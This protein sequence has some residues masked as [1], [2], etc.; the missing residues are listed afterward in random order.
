MKKANTK[1]YEISPWPWKFGFDT[2]NRLGILS[3]RNE[4]IC[5]ANAWM[6]A[7][8]PA[9]AEANGLL[10]TVAP[11]LRQA[12]LLLI[13]NTCAKCRMRMRILDKDGIPLC[14]IDGDCPKGLDDAKHIIAKSYGKEN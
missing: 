13:Q 2:N 7:G 3:S 6:G 8:D 10:M 5:D 4:L 12:L 1:K 11:E 14:E 9:T